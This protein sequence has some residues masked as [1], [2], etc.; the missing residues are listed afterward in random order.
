MAISAEP[1]NDPAHWRKRA[2]ECRLTAKQ[3]TDPEQMQTLLEIAARYDQ[4][5]ALIESAQS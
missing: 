4:L 2:E 3:L 5:A 1:L